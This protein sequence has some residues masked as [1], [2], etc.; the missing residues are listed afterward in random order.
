[1][2]LSKTHGPRREKTCLRGLWSTQGQTSLCIFAVWSAPLLFTFKKVSYVNILQVKFQFLASLR[3]WGD[4]FETGSVGHPEDRFFSPRGPLYPYWSVL[5]STQENIPIW[6]M[7]IFK[8]VK[9]QLKQLNK[10]FSMIVYAH[11]LKNSVNRE[12]TLKPVLSSHSKKKDK[13]K[14]LLTNGSLI[15]VESIAECSNGS[16]QQYFLP[17]L[18]KSLSWKPIL[19]FFLSGRLRQVLLLSIKFSFQI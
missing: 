2:F 1:M 6:L 4:W 5:T 13:T 14:I 7:F 9:H 12:D 17:A 15:K 8:D 18:S 10:L 11:V 16:I 3:S 19:V